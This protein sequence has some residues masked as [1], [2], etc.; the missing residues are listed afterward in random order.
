MPEKPGQKTGVPFD[1]R[2]CTRYNMNSNG[3]HLLQCQGQI[4][5]LVLVSFFLDLVSCLAAGPG[6][7]CPAAVNHV[8]QLCYKVDFDVDSDDSLR[9]GRLCS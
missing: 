7:D 2:R 9:C 1:M 3:G 5:C 6:V 8:L 4:V